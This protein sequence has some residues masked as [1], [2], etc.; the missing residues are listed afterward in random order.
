MWPASYLDS[1]VPI[2][3]GYTEGV[4]TAGTQAV[5]SKSYRESSGTKKP[6]ESEQLGKPGLSD[7][8]F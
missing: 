1:I 8:K 3:R 4:G 2:R 5:D 6:G 7:A